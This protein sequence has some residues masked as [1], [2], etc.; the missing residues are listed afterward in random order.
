MKLKFHLNDQQVLEHY[1]Y[2][3]KDSVETWTIDESLFKTIDKKDLTL[4]VKKST[5]G[6]F[7]S[8]IEEKKFKM[9]DLGTKCEH[10]KEITLGKDS[11]CTFIFAIR[12]PLK[13]TEYEEVPT[14]K[15]VIDTFIKPFREID[16]VAPSV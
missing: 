11:T 5:L 4:D 6:I 15:L 14:P 12:Q 10:T 13:S 16:Y 9:S 3:N 2:Q 1:F 7:K 8:T